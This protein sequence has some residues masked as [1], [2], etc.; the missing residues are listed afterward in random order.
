MRPTPTAR[1]LLAVLIFAGVASVTAYVAQVDPHLD[2]SQI[3]V[4]SAALKRHDPALFAGDGVYGTELWRFHT[5][6]LQGLLELSLVPTGYE[7]PTLPFRLLAPLALMIYLSGM[8]ALLYRQSRS[9][10]VSA[11]VAVLSAMVIPTP[12]G[13]F[14]GIG[15]VASV[16]PGGLVLS[17]T[18][19]VILSYLR[20]ARH[21]RVV[22]V[23]AFI[24]LCG[25]I[26]LATAGNMALVLLIVH[27]CRWRSWRTAA[28]GACGVLAALAA[29]APYVLYGFGV[30]ATLLQAAG[31]W[32]SMSAAADALRLVGRDLLY[33]RVLEGVPNWLAFCAALGVPAAVVLTRA[34]RFRGR[35]IRLWVW[36]LIAA[37][38]VGLGFHAVSQLYGTVRGQAPPVLAF[39]GALRL[40]MLPLYVLFAQT[41]TN[42]FRMV[43]GHRVWVRWACVALAAVWI[44]PSDNFRV[45]RHRIYFLATSFMPAEDTPLRVRE[46]RAQAERRD[47]LRRIGAW[48]RRDGDVPVRSLFLFD[49]PAFR[50]LSRRGLYAS[51]SDALFYYYAAPARLDDWA[52][53]IRRQDRLL[54][55]RS[56]AK[57]SL[58]ELRAYAEDRAGASRYADVRR[59]FAVLRV[60]DAPPPEH[61]EPISGDW[62][63]HYRV[64][65]LWPWAP[66]IP[67]NG[68]PTRP[69]TRLTTRRKENP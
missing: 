8:Y 47:E 63:E 59:W 16:T 14:W 60:E 56:G 11:F 27:L 64:Y 43:R 31:G 36:F 62:G 66:T 26:D 52:R 68:T 3:D 69:T 55:A 18:P 7:D 37:T 51:P 33:P 57:V 45:L 32:A 23:F 41:L 50:M 49:D 22:L 29:A 58:A 48:A 9:W 5:P 19:L 42:L 4:A 24:G 1:H 46:L 17:L 40:A 61:A 67:L 44:A 6:A 15:S 2:D 21:W 30:R 39:V 65:R 13:L 12:G 53:R 10:S 28:T 25:N 38:L 34:R 20:Y 35:D 54:H